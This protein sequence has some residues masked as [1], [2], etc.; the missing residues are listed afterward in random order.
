MPPPASARAGVKGGLP[1][2]PP[3]LGGR[4]ADQQIKDLQSQRAGGGKG[5][6]MDGV[7]EF[8]SD[9]YGASSNKFDGYATELP[10]ENDEQADPS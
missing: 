9:I 5:S 2:P 10:S 1:T 7:G 8:D 3:T 4:M 6:A